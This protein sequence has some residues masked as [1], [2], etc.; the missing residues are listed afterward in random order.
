MC[1]YYVCNE[2]I[3]MPVCMCGPNSQIFLF[4]A[5]KEGITWYFA[6]EIV[7]FCVSLSLY[8][9]K[10]KLSRRPTKK[11]EKRGERRRERKKQN[12]NFIQLPT[13]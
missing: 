13:R 9:S 2:H 5:L 1:N 10:L 7:F 8:L 12:P 4:E 3:I 11:R 6:R